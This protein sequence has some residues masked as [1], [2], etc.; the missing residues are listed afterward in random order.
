MPEHLPS[1][2]KSG[3]GF[4]GLGEAFEAGRSAAAQALAGLGGEA[5]ALVMVFATP[6]FDLP[7]LLTGVRSL[8]GTAILIGS[9]GSG[10]IIAGKYLGFGGGV[11]VLALTAGPYRFSAASE[12]DIGVDDLEEAGRRLARRSRDGAGPSPFATA[13]L[14]TDSLLG[15]LQQFVQGVYR[16]AGAQ[17]ALVGGAAGDE[18]RFLKSSVFHGDQILDKGALVLWIASEGPIQVVTRHGWRPIGAPLLVTRSEGTRIM[19]LGGRPAALAYEEALDLEAPLTRENFWATSIHHPMGL[20]QPDGTHVIRVARAKDEEGVLTVMG[21]APAV[22]SL[23]QVMEGS[24]DSLLDVTGEVVE[25]SLRSR[26]MASVLLT[27]SCAARAMILGER[28]SEEASRLQAAAGVVPIFGFYCCSEF[29]RA[30]GVLATHN[31]TLT[32]VAL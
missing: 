18:Q 10:E 24:A 7:T 1:G 30:S 22:G 16:V 21:G 14:I 31:A 2:L 32:A 11:G 8:T 26:P 25:A 12:G 20:T 28:A 29:A 17:V 19:E 15:D 9:T 3:T 23:V 4:S 6:R 27:F 13:L 5:P